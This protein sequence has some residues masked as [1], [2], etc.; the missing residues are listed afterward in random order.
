METVPRAIPN[1]IRQVL[2]GKPPVIHGDGGDIRDYV[3][4]SD[5]VEATLLALAHDSHDVQIYNV[6]TGSGHSTLAIAERIIQ[7]TGKRVKP[8]LEAIQ[9]SACKVVCDISHARKSLGYE[10]R[11]SI[12]TG[13]LDEVQYF[14]DH[15][16][17]WGV[18]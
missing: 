5:V 13:L 11:V 17:L 9:H 6:G 7:L 12:D 10:P 14:F 16:K 2:A 18:Q 8:I 4:V 3:H 15:P 1:F